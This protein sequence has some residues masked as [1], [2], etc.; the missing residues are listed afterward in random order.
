MQRFVSAEA[1]NRG[2]VVTRSGQSAALQTHAFTLVELLIVVAIISLLVQ[3]ALPAVEMARESARNTACQNNLRQLGMACQIH[4]STHNQFPTGGWGFAWA[5]DPDRGTGRRQPGG[6][7]YNVLPYI[8]QQALHDLGRKKDE[9][10]KRAALTQMCQTPLKLLICPSRR[11]AKAYPYWEFAAY[12]MHNTDELEKVG[13]TD[14]AANAGDE[15]SHGVAGPK[16]LAEG[17]A[18]DYRWYDPSRPEYDSST[19]TGVVYQRSEVGPQQVID[20]MSSTY[21]A[22]EKFLRPKRYKTGEDGGDDQ[23][24]YSGADPD[25]LRW[26]ASKRDFP[27]PPRRDEDG[28]LSGRY[29]FGSRHP[30]AINMAYC[31][32]SVREIAYDV[33]LEVHRAAGNR[34]DEKSLQRSR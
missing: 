5:G 9:A 6:W 2:R 20:G 13:K 19:S 31:D 10:A 11:R 32:G 15:F 22:G 21:L 23:T 26:T 33:D 24:M 4:V 30:S 18:E 17:D 8:E 7:I 28:G 34:Q 12:P 27:L 25:I 29:Q 3:L 14:Y 16:T 1:D